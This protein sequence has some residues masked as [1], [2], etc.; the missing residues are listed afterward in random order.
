MLTKLRQIDTTI[1]I[2]AL[3]LL[4]SYCFGQVQQS[5]RYET[6]IPD[7][8]R[9]HY[10]VVSVQERGIILYRRFTTAPGNQVELMRVD[11]SLQEVWRGFVQLNLDEAVMFTYVKKDLIYLLIKSRNN[12]Q[13]DL[14]IVEM[15]IETGNYNLY[16]VKNLIPFTPTEFTITNGAALI[17]GYFNYRPLILHYNFKLLQSKILP[18]FFNE[19]GELTQMKPNENGSVDVIVS[20]KNFNKQKVLWIRNYDSSGSLLRTAIL[21]PAEKNNL[22][23]G[24]S[25]NMPNGDQIVSGVYGRRGDY[26][27]GIFIASINVLGE[28]AIKY[29]TFAELEHFFNYMKARREK[30]VKEKIERRRIKGKRIKFNYRILVQQLIPYGNQYILLGEAFYPH[31]VNTGNM[32]SPYSA[33]YNV[34]S[35]YMPSTRTDLIFDGYQYTHAVVIGFDKNGNLLWDNSFEIN[36]VKTFDL[37]QFVKIYPLDNRIALLYLFENAIRNKI[38]SGAEVL[39]GKS[40]DEMKLKFID[41]QVKKRETEF[42]KLDYWYGRN[43]FAYGVQKVHNLREPHIETLRNVFFV[44]KITFIK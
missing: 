10:K 9:E 4:S 25:L 15:K 43:F 28:Y 34:R 8:E 31:Y 13:G 39:E 36:D 44:N 37:E 30:R 2:T 3:T 1:L 6:I 20:A 14:L 26:S 27:R 32:Y 21:E 33:N 40:V 12:V 16:S 5:H 41:D 24:R 11:T 19:P 29:Y 17:G 22:I 7:N 38:I 42:S 35:Y 23:F 18:G